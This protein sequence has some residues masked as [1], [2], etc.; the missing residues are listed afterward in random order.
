MNL[1]WKLASVLKK[2]SPPSLLQS[3]NG[4]RLPVI[5]AMLDK[6]SAL[7]KIE[8]TDSAPRKA[9]RSDP[10]LMMLG[11]NYRTSSFVFDSI[12]HR[13]KPEEENAYMP[14]REGL[15]AGDRAPNAPRLVRSDGSSTMLFDIF[16]PTHHTALIFAP[17]VEAA[18]SHLDIITGENGRIVSFVVLPEGSR[19][20]DAK[21]DGAQVIVDSEGHAKAA[22]LEKNGFGEDD[23][24]AYLVRP[25]SYIGALAGR[26]G[27]SLQEYIAKVFV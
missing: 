18:K 11:I 25:D 6:T 10:A 3:Y 24:F 5:A 15:W 8:H 1:G 4:E 14:T 12:H 22:Y 26:D 27:R 19:M 2:H 20:D 17:T 16:K 9:D 23:I 13:L 21:V 7:F